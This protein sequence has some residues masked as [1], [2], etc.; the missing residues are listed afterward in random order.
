MD[1]LIIV[2]A[3]DYY[4]QIIGPAI[5]T[6]VREGQVC[7]D[8]VVDIVDAFDD[9]S[10]SFF[11]KATYLKREKD[12]SLSSLLSSYASVDPVI[13][14][15]HANQLHTHDAID[16][17]EAGFRVMLEKPYSISSAEFAQLQ[18]AMEKFPGKIALLEYYLS[19][20]AAPLLLSFGHVARGSF[21]T[22][23][24]HGVQ[25]VDESF[26]QLREK[27][28]RIVSVSV[29][30]LEGEG[31]T[32]TVAHR[33]PHL[34]DRQRGGGMIFDLAGHALAPI[35]ALSDVIGNIVLD[36]ATTVRCAWAHEYAAM[37]KEQ[38]ALP[39]YHIGES[40][41]KIQLCTDS[42]VPI[43]VRVGKYTPSQANQRGITLVG[44]CGKVFIDL[45]DCGLYYE[46][47]LVASIAKLPKTKYIAVLAAALAELRGEDLFVSQRATQIA[48]TTQQLVLSLVGL[49]QK[50]TP[51]SVMYD[52]GADPD[53]I[54]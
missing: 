23:S 1:H 40:F 50:E 42:H 20:K 48:Q 47:Q 32:G 39:V 36:D 6:L 35:V 16:L 30:V 49:A 44:E 15:G 2:G 37:A 53:T 21:Y 25:V 29:D 7:V 13:L 22:E 17:L 28:G 33:G 3:G 12:Q 41:A 51:L 11:E 9:G 26:W 34:V 19:M 31:L 52:T 38:Y 45:S 46:Q 43:T 14:L 18:T 4:R 24:S 5:D 8:A 27:I 54:F 10:F